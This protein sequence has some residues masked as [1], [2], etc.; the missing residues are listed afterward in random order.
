M[1][2]LY[3][4]KSLKIDGAVAAIDFIDVASA[5]VTKVE[6]TTADEART[7]REALDTQKARGIT[8]RNGAIEDFRGTISFNPKVPG[9]AILHP[10]GDENFG[11]FIPVKLGFEV[12]GGDLPANG[13]AMGQATMVDGAMVVYQ[14]AVRELGFA[15]DRA[16]RPN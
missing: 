10:D 16:P 15:P 9:E 1:F 2:G 14:I 7:L 8:T 3:N 6:I 11:N 4:P 12:E 13:Y 5:E